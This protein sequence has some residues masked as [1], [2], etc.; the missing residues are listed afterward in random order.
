MFWIQTVV[1]SG[2]TSDRGSDKV[3]DDSGVQYSKQVDLSNKSDH[4]TSRPGFQDGGPGASCAF[5]QHI[6]LL[7]KYKSLPYTEDHDN[8]GDV[9]KF[10]T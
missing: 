1:Y 4:R 2:K 8:I 9:D 7:G 6:N 3:R 5:W 10:Q